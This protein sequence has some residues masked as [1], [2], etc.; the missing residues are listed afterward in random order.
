MENND[1]FV[2]LEQKEDGL[3]NVSLELLAPAQDMAQHTGGRVCGMLIGAPG[4]GALAEKA[5]AS[6]ADVVYVVEGEEYAVYSTDAY[7]TAVTEVL[8]TYEPTA[9]MIGA[10]PLGVD[11]APRVAARLE[12]GLTADVTGIRWDEANNCIGWTMPA[13][14][15]R[16]MATIL[17]PVKRPQMATVR[18]NVFEI[19]PAGP[20]HRGEVITENIHV[21]ETSIRAKLKEI[22]SDF[23]REAAELSEAD[24]VVS[25]GYGCGNRGG[26]A[27]VEALADAL[28][29]AVGASRAAVDAGWV[30]L[31]QQ[32]GQSGVTVRPKLYIACGISGAVQ[33][34]AGMDR[35]GLIV[36][37]N[38]DPNAA[39]FN[40]ADYG[41]V[42]DLR[43]VI[44]LFLDEI[45]K[46]KKGN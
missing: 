21:A 45:N 46:I 29:G 31:A 28:G 23:S 19:R 12:T 8:R 25:G 7:A 13:Y 1:I 10:T 9:V 17:C 35:S 20:D 15:G 32:V 3:A 18:P 42:G 26:F 14:G 24:I 36:A 16:M 34:N 33:H 2:Y 44:P 40:I 41:I 22:L 27:L 39:I 30:P 11:F 6:G 5:I 43:E 37:I 38:T 4:T